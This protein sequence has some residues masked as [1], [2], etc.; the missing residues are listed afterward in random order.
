MDDQLRLF[1]R[2]WATLH[3]I[4][5]T[6]SYLMRE[7]NYS[8]PLSN[9]TEYVSHLFPPYFPSDAQLRRWPCWGRMGFVK[10]GRPFVPSFSNTN[11]AAST[12]TPLSSCRF[13]SPTSIDQVFWSIRSVSFAEFSDTISTEELQ[14]RENIDICYNRILRSWADYRNSHPSSMPLLDLLKQIKYAT[15]FTTSI[16]VGSFHPQNKTIL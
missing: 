6:Y 11:L 13:S 9:N 2:T 10:N 8:I 7:L 16:F 3:V 12:I 4:D 1:N 5:F 14:I 15:L